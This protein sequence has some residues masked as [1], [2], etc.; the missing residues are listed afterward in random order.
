MKEKA[1]A[2]KD[3]NANCCHVNLRDLRILPKSYILENANMSAN[4]YTL[5]Y[6]K[7]AYNEMIRSIRACVES[8]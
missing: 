3:T 6:P 1:S 7:Q 2:S 5:T 4:E 8:Y